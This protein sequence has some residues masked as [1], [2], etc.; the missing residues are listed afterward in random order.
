MGEPGEPRPG[1]R[2]GA[3]L[4]YYRFPTLSAGKIVFTT[5]GNLWT[6]PIEGGIAHRLTRYPGRQAFAELSPDGT[7]IAFTAAYQ[8]NEDVW[9]MPAVGGEPLR[10]TAHPAPDHVIGWS[11]DGKSV[12]FRSTRDT[13]TRDPHAYSVALD[14]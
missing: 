3:P 9:V 12:L 5:E 6:V 1:V 14:G 7:K 10:L 11:P 13:A 4:G 2:S 8:G